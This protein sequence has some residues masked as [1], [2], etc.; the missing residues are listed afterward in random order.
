MQQNQARQVKAKKQRRKN[1]TS[2]E[3][4]SVTEDAEGI[5]EARANITQQSVITEDG[6]IHETLLTQGK[7]KYQYK[8]EYIGFMLRTKESERWPTKVVTPEKYL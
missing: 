5:A 3:E 1:K 4:G 2:E 7:R 8:S 6:I